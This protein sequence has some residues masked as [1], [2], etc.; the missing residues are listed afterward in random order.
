MRAGDPGRP[1]LGCPVESFLHLRPTMPATGPSIPP[2]ASS[3][4][5]NRCMSIPGFELKLPTLVPVVS[6]S[7]VLRSCQEVRSKSGQGPVKVRPAPF[8]GPVEHAAAR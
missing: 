2:G 4:R 5:G 6:R 7:V 8:P 3:E 1:K